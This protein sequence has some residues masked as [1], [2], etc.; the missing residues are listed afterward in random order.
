MWR[1]DTIPP[2]GFGSISGDVKMNDRV[3]QKEIEELKERLDKLEEKVKNITY[4]KWA[5]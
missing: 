1:W 3:V 4:N 2:C 5:F